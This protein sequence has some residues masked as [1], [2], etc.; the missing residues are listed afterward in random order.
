[1]PGP[2]SCV[3][4]RFSWSPYVTAL[5]DCD[6]P[7]ETFCLRP[8]R[9]CGSMNS[10]PGGHLCSADGRPRPASR[11]GRPD[12]RTACTGAGV[13]IRSAGGIPRPGTG[14]RPPPTLSD[15]TI[16][17]MAAAVATAAA[18]VAYERETAWRHWRRTCPV[19]Q[20]GLSWSTLAGRCWR[21]ECRLCGYA[22]PFDPKATDW[23]GAW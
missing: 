13:G 7:S 2:V 15:A 14:P 21:A 23:D 4:V 3:G 5:K 16:G 20:T 9:R 1:M 18:V 12:S 17:G 10:G 19:C 6:Q 8:P 11:P 22:G